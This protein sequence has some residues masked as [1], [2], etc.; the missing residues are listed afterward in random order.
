LSCRRK[1]RKSETAANRCAALSP[2]LL[3]LPPLKLRHVHPYFGSAG[4]VRFLRV[5]SVKYACLIVCLL[6]LLCLPRFFPVC[7]T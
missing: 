7:F 1:R 4:A 5:Q 3:L 2:S 6:L